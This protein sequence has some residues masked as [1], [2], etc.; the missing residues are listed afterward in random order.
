MDQL[1]ERY[2]F[3]IAPGIAIPAFTAGQLVPDGATTNDWHLWAGFTFPIN[4]S[5]QPAA[6]VPS[7]L[8]SDGLPIGL[9]IIGARGHDAAV[10]GLAE[11][12]ETAFPQHFCERPHKKGEPIGPPSSSRDSRLSRRDASPCRHRLPTSAAWRGRR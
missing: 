8:T 6:S 2:D 9:Q 11:S 5:Q 7:G 12:F 3:L 10:L 4:L 1:L